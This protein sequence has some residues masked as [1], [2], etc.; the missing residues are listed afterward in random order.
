MQLDGPSCRGKEQSH[1]RD[2]LALALAAAE[3]LTAEGEEQ[4]AGGERW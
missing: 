3:G 2:D 1:V 4:E